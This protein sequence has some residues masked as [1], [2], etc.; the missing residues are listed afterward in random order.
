[1]KGCNT[2]QVIDK[3]TDCVVL[4]L[5]ETKCCN[6]KHHLLSEKKNQEF[7]VVVNIGMDRVNKTKPNPYS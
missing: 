3:I 2:G 6:N 1:M 5:A 4:S 7:L